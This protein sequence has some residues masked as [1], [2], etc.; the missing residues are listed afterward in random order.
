MERV[1]RAP[2]CPEMSSRV[3]FSVRE[4]SKYILRTQ[5][6]N[7]AKPGHTL[8]LPLLTAQKRN[9]KPKLSP[10]SKISNFQYQNRHL[11]RHQ[12]TLI[13][14][15]SRLN[16]YLHPVSPTPYHPA[17]PSSHLTKSQIPR[18]RIRR[19]KKN[20]ER[21]TAWPQRRPQAQDH[22][23]RRPLG[24]SALQEA[25]A[26]DGV[27]VLALRRLLARQGHRAGEGG[28]RGQTTEQRHQEM[29]ACAADQEREEGHGFRYVRGRSICL[30]IY[31]FYLVWY[32]RR[33]FEEEQATPKLELRA[34]LRDMVYCSTERRLSEFRG[35]E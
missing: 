19:P 10:H 29:R 24:G 14:S 20:D 27:Q 9:A 35:R 15:T 28:R 33:R 26:G 12:P 8:I 16:T 30:S 1:A 4:D 17:P 21:Q 32:S 5:Y 13:P 31:S 22:A 18:S 34:N 11:R 2:F 7:S 25:A 6:T 23:P 3:D